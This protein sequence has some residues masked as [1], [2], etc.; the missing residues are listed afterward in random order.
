VLITLYVI[1]ASSAETTLASG[2][3]G[4]CSAHLPPKDRGPQQNPTIGAIFRQH[5]KAYRAKHPLTPEQAK[6]LSDIATCRTAELGGHIQHCPECG[7]TEPRYNS[8]GNRHCPQCQGQKSAEWVEARAEKLL[9]VGHF[10][11]VF[12]V[13]EELRP[14]ALQN[15][16]LFYDLM[17]SSAAE[18]LATLAKDCLNARLGFTIVLHTWSRALALHPHVHCIVSGGGLDVCSEE[19]VDAKPDYLFPEARMR[20]LFRARLLQG[21]YAAY[22]TKQLKL[23]GSC[24]ELEDPIRFGGFIRRMWRAKWVVNIQAPFGSP[25]HV[26]KYLGRYTH[27]VGIS[28]MRLVHADDNEIC[29]VTR[30]QKTVT[31]SAEE[32]I[33]RFLLHV[34]PA[35]YHKIRH[36]GLYSSH[37]VRALLSVAIAALR[38]TRDA[39]GTAAVERLEHTLSEMTANSAAYGYDP[40]TCPA[41]GRGILVTL[42]E[43]MP[44][45]A[46]RCY[47]PDAQDTS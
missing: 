30:E 6:A 26:L 42:S 7:Y 8:C 4:T 31:V 9:P 40:V 16:E 22:R 46:P 20:S 13:P 43:A 39:E 1:G 41:C 23:C 34:L 28:N 17:F 3:G 21:F 14:L 38:E 11:V 19:W 35:S 37:G 2:I 10:H 32:F 24:G 5:G 45:V 33:R 27:R 18:T 36:Y 29:F 12:T 44:T 15:Q 25:E 47:G